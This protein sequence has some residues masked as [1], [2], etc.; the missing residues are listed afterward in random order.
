MNS[1]SLTWLHL[2]DVLVLSQ[3]QLIRL[4]LQ[5][6]MDKSTLV[7]PP[8]LFG[9]CAAGKCA[10]ATSPFF[11]VR[12]IRKALDQLEPCDFKQSAYNEYLGKVELNRPIYCDPLTWRGLPGRTCC[13]PQ[14]PQ[15]NFPLMSLFPANASAFDENPIP[16]DWRN[17]QDVM[18]LPST[19]RIVILL[20][21][22]TEVPLRGGSLWIY[23]TIEAWTKVRQTPVIVVDYT[24]TSNFQYFQNTANARTLGQAIGYAIVKWRIAE[25]T[26]LAGFSLGGQM[27]SEV[28]KF[29]QRHGQLIKECVALDPA[30][31]GFDSGAP[32]MHLTPDDCALVQVIHSSSES[33][34][35]S[36]GALSLQLGSYFHLGSC[37]FWLNCG[38]NQAADCQFPVLGATMDNVPARLYSYT[39]AIG[40]AHSRAPLVYSASVAGKCNYTGNQ[41]TNCND[42]R[43]TNGCRVN[44]QGEQMRL[45]P[46][47]SCKKEYRKDFYVQTQGNTYPYCPR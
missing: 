13:F 1:I 10:D 24:N 16:L 17:E 43:L 6:I 5:T 27:I 38:R 2:L 36:T 26:H 25:R 12:M 23:P 14:L 33:M 32:L 29:T 45:P 11:G 3:A 42:F 7:P 28:G 34:P 21:G 40:C 30:G 47:N 8:L 44:F 15:A 46:F 39:I 20:H 4:A 37:D 35:D 41:C 19:G 9:E 31:P 18:K 22:W